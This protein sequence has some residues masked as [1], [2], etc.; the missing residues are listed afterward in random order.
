VDNSR[1]GSMMA[2]IACVAVL[3]A[4]ATEPPLEVSAVSEVAHEDVHIQHVI[5]VLPKPRPIK[6]AATKRK[7]CGQDY[8]LF[9]GKCLSRLE[10]WHL[11][12]AI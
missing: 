11:R 5:P 8:R 12:G 4:C 6:R 7:V 3:S 10:T 1:L 2:A 9:N